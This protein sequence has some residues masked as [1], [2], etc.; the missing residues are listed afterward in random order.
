MVFFGFV[1]SCFVLNCVVF[2][3]YV[4]SAFVMLGLVICLTQYLQGLPLQ[5]LT[6]FP[7]AGELRSATLSSWIS[8]NFYHIPFT[9]LVKKF[10]N[11][12]LYVCQ[13]LL[14]VMKDPTS[15]FLETGFYHFSI[16]LGKIIIFHIFTPQVPWPVHLRLPSPLPCPSS[17]TQ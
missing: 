17:C 10:K 15:K 9:S 13:K 2:S 1:V 3:N 16:F 5:S 12:Q 7:S 8:V 6:H 14:Y 4:K 11:L